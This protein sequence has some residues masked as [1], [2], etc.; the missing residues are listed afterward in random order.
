MH[1]W[2]Q[3]MVDVLII[4]MA[5]ILIL[6]ALG[7]IVLH[8]ITTSNSKRVEQIKR[9]IMRML[10]VK[11][12]LEF[13]REQIH[14]LLDQNGEV[15]SLEDIRGIQSNRGAIAITIVVDEINESQRELLRSIIL[16]DQ[17]Y[18]A[19]IRKKLHA[20]NSDWVG[21]FT[22]LVAELRLSVL[23]EE[24][25][26]N[27]YRWPKK[28]DNQEISLL[29]L[30]MCASRDKLLTLFSDPS[31][32]LILSFRSLQE[33]FACYTG[34]HAELCRMLLGKSPDSYV[35]RSCIHEIG[36]RE[37]TELCPLVMPYLR[38]ENVNILVD[39]I[40]TL[41]RLRYSP[42]E[43]SIRRYTSHPE[44]CV[45]STAATALSEIAPDR[46]YEELLRCLCDREWW[47]RF[48]AAEALSKLPGHPSLMADVQALNDRFA[49]EMMRYIQERNELLREEVK[50]S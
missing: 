15:H 26:A 36:T 24:V 4:V 29:A 11:Q 22:K 17:W 3:T 20:G 37:M 45:R 25:L 38:S 16:Q 41:G 13:L 23:D 35:T 34:D 21:V 30:F 50:A 48:H 39:S 40:R 7:L 6:F 8:I 14:Q 27:L 31:F 2:I 28:A 10:S 18:M 47:V 33:L 46:C 49:F 42:A 44:W 1:T 32:H 12:D 19:H 43:E 5:S 9:R